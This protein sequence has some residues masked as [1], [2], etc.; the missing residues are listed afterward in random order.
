[1]AIVGD[2]LNE[3][4]IKQINQRQSAHGSG[5]NGDERTLEELTY[6]NSKTAWIKFASGVSVSS[7]KLEDLGFAP[8]SAEISELVGTG[9]A[10]KYV[11]YNGIS[12]LTDTNEQAYRLLPFSADNYE[13]SSDY[14]I[15]PTPGII[16]L[17]VKALNRGSLKK[18]TIKL[19]VQDRSQLSIIDTLYMRLGYTVLLEWGNSVFLDNNGNLDTVKETVVERKDYFFSN[20]GGKSA[21]YTDVLRLIEYYRGKYCGNYDGMLGKISNFSWT[22]NQDGSYDVDLTVIS[23][24]DVVESLKSNVTANKNTID[25][26]EK[27]PLPA[28]ENSIINIRRKDN[29]LFSLLHAMRIISTTPEGKSSDKDFLLTIDGTEYG[30]FISSGSATIKY[31]ENKLEFKA[32]HTL[33]KWNND[34]TKYAP[35]DANNFTYADISAF[36]TDPTEDALLSQKALEEGI[37]KYPFFQIDSVAVYVANANSPTRDTWLPLNG[38]RGSMSTLNAPVTSSTRPDQPANGSYSFQEVITRTGGDPKLNIQSDKSQ[39]FAPGMTSNLLKYKVNVSNNKKTASGTEYTFNNIAAISFPLALFPVELKNFVETFRSNFE[40]TKFLKVHYNFPKYLW[41]YFV[42]GNYGVFYAGLTN[43]FGTNG[44]NF[45]LGSPLLKTKEYPQD[46]EPSLKS[47]TSANQNDPAITKKIDELWAKF[48]AE[49]QIPKELMKAPE[50]DPTTGKPKDSNYEFF[51]RF[52]ANN[53]AEA[54]TANVNTTADY[55]FQEKPFFWATPKFEKKLIPTNVQS[56][57]NPLKNLIYDTKGVCKL[58]TEPTS[59]YLRFGFLL[60]LLIDK[61][62]FKID[63][64]ENNH[65]DNSSIFLINNATGSSEMLCISSKTTGQISYDWKT[66]IVR[67]DKFTKPWIDASDVNKGSQVVFPQLNAWAKEDIKGIADENKEYTVADVMN[68][69]LNFDF[70]GQ[71]MQSNT[72]EK[73]NTAI[74]GFINSI[75]TGL[76][77]ALGGINN[78]EPIIDETTNT[79]SIVDTSPKYI[80]TPNNVFSVERNDSYQLQLYGYTPNLILAPNIATYYPTQAPHYEST[81]ARKVNLKTAITPEYAT[82]I[83]VGAAA[84]GYVKGVEATSFAKW[85]TGINDRFKPNFIPADS[86]IAGKTPSTSTSNTTEN[87]EESA[88]ITDTLGSY[89][90]IMTSTT[91]APL[92]CFGI[93]KT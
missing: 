10:Q 39:T 84:G 18:A 6:L 7:S 82:M 11:L 81:F 37:K 31:V 67:R 77:K 60:Q 65:K 89:Q 53:A 72:D 90:Q 12:T 28:Q 56:F 91:E 14:G 13:A 87:E 92:I 47:I 44:T 80:S 3:F 5:Q 55:D 69:Y 17:D 49:N 24:G 57:D 74:Y 42:G 38:T 26:V 62:I 48:Q 20:N 52:V 83:T 40:S 63:E 58:N 29:V 34:A 78:L 79:L 22:F 59:Y 33:M 88:S 27:T 43:K 21:P 30:N 66:C 75:C 23:W 19:K 64:Q 45:T 86:E 51:H 61:V 41:G 8:G 50:Y 85:N 68:V 2:E 15:I 71:C 46:T 93:Q 73:G 4:V 54:T 32:T 35:V 1:M 76:N 9:L 70:I 25:F 16:D 36:L